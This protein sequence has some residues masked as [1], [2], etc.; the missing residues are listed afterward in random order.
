[1]KKARDKTIMY[2]LN[3]DEERLQK[4]REVVKRGL[5]KCCKGNVN[6]YFYDN[7]DE[8]K[9]RKAMESYASRVNS[10]EILGFINESTLGAKYG[11]IFADT[12]LY[13]RKKS[14]IK[15]FVS[16]GDCKKEVSR[17][18]SIFER[19][20]YNFEAVCEMIRNVKNVD[21]PTLS[22]L[23]DKGTDW[24]EKAVD[25]QQIVS[26]TGLAIKDFRE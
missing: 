2:N 11:V 9:M 20:T 21:R 8:K 16:Y 7:M 25:I 12:G 13:Y 22:E 5:A 19:E 14:G 23:V 10:E 4:K 6:A 18:K 24:V 17:L 26:E 15:G 3:M 1:M